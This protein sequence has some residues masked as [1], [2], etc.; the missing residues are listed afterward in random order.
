MTSFIERLFLFVHEYIL[1]TL[2]RIFFTFLKM[3]TSSIIKKDICN[4]GMDAYKA[5]TDRVTTT[6]AN[7]CIVILA[8]FKNSDKV[9]IEHRYTIPSDPNAKNVKKCFEHVYKHIKKSKIK[10]EISL[11]LL[12]LM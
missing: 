12:I 1:Q 4:I 10:A 11:V 3:A 8:L 5:V 6:G 7:T 2:F 9:F